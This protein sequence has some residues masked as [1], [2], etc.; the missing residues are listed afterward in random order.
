M[1][2]RHINALQIH[3]GAYSPRAILR[4]LIVAIDEA[5]NEPSNHTVEFANNCLQYDAACRVILFNLTVAS[6]F[7]IADHELKQYNALLRECSLKAK[8]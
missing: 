3:A 8:P 4:S 6:H 7:D 2:Q 5:A 1:S